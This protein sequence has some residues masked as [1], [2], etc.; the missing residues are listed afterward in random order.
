MRKNNKYSREF[1]L[2]VVKKY[3]EG[4]YSLQKIVDDFKI[5]SKTQVHAWLKSYEKDGENAF[6]FETRG[7]PK[8]KRV[9]KENFIFDNLEDE[10]RFLKME[11]EYLKKLCDLLKSKFK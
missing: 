8:E 1:K 11:N 5:P 3:L 7:N 9:V 4:N 6:R 10:I 2:K